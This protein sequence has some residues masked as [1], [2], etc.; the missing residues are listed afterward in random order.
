[1]KPISV[2]CCYIKDLL[3]LKVKNKPHDDCKCLS[4]YSQVFS[5]GAN[6]YAHKK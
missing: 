6:N 5:T 3:F 1:V 2:C 4:A